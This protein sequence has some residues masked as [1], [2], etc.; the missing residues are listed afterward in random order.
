[1]N[2]I[3]KFSKVSENQFIK[4]YLDCF[5][6]ETVEASREAYQSLILPK[7]ATVGSAGYD[8]VTPITFT[9]QPNESIKIPTGIKAQM[10]DGWVLL[11]FPRSGL[12]FKFHMELENTIGV[13]DQDYIHAKNEGHIFIKIYN[14]SEEKK[15]ILV[16]KGEAFAQ[17]IF[18]PFGITGDDEV[19]TLR[20]GGF[21]STDQK[22]IK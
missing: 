8:F 1:M 4:D 22:V 5:P 15:T 11:L 3:A 12:G 17:G 10:D 7:R 20:Q 18:L 21:G 6:K 16:N 13:V 2:I 14:A 9:L 19:D